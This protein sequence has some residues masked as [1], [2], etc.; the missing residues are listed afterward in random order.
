MDKNTQQVNSEVTVIEEDGRFYGVL[1]VDG[2]E[3]REP[4]CEVLNQLPIDKQKYWMR[5]CIVRLEQKAKAFKSQT[6]ARKARALMA[7]NRT[8]REV[9]TAQFFESI[10]VERV[11]EGNEVGNGDKLGNEALNG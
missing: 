7:A 6:L 4:L 11:E 3:F 9:E 10:G 2:Q 5:R 1:V 8:M